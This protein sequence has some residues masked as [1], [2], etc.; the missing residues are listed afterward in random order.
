LAGCQTPPATAQA[1]GAEPAAAVVDVQVA[2][3]SLGPIESTLEISGTLA[4][5]SRVPVKPRVPGAIER[6]LVDIGDGVREGQTIATLDRR[7]IDAQADAAM[8]AVA[9]AQAAL[10]SADAALANATLEH[11]R[12]KVLFDGGALPRQRLDAAETARRA[13][14]AQRNLATATLA[15]AEASL[16]RA[17]EVQRD[18]IITAPVTGFIVERNYDAGAIPGDKPVVVVAD[19]R[20]MRLEAGVSELDAGRLR[21]GQSARVDVQA[22]PGRI[23]E[24]AVAAM[25][26]EVDARNRHVRIEVHVPNDGRSLLSGMFATARIVQAREASAVLVPL[27]AVGTR[28]G[29]RVVLKVTG[30]VVTPVEVSEGI[31]DGLRVQ[32]AEGLQAGDTVVADARRQIAPG[33]TVR[34][35]AMR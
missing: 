27:E 25:A 11:E 22:L 10:E 17:R 5:R 30:G 3:A 9:V 14:S 32:I 6:L 12:A 26:P 7:E 1:A 23:F 33:T 8:A 31:A 15:Q 4:P 18:T 19:L 13:G 35:V 28:D 34:P 16:R 20:Q 21:L 2:T 24:G 29:R